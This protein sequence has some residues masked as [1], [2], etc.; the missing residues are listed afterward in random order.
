MLLDL[1]LSFKALERQRKCLGR[2]RQRK[3]RENIPVYHQRPYPF[4]VSHTFSYIF[5][6]NK[7]L[8]F[9]ADRARKQ[10]RTQHLSLGKTLAAA[11]HVPHQKFSARGC[12][13]KVSN[14]INM[15]PVGYQSLKT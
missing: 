12:F 10:P 7:K 14:Y 5:L 1:F 9:P 6:L 4:F 3:C 8:L 2:E 11:G 15:L 13:G